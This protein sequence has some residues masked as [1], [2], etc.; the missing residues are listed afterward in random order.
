MFTVDVASLK[1]AT[2]ITKRVAPTRTTVPMA[3]NIFLKVV[4]GQ[5]WLHATDFEKSVRARVDGKFDEDIAV[6]VPPV[7]C[8]VVA[9]LQSPTAM[10]SLNGDKLR[11]E[12]GGTKMNFATM[13]EDMFPLM[14][15]PLPTTFKI[16]SSVLKDAIS[17]CLPFAS[18]DKSRPILNSVIMYSHNN[19]LT[20]SSL[21]GLRIS[22]YITDVKFDGWASIPVSSASE[23]AR[24]LSG[25]VVDVGCTNASISF[26]FCDTLIVTQLIDGQELD[27]DGYNLFSIDGAGVLNFNAPE[28]LRAV[29]TMSL[30]NGYGVNAVKVLP[31]KNS[32]T[33]TVEDSANG[34]DITIGADNTTHAKFLV[35]TNYLREAL[36]VVDGDARVYVY[37]DKRPVVLMDNNDNF[38]HVLFPMVFR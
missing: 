31:E 14:M 17:K 19:K 9:T 7:F 21:D 34:G 32:I 15:E 12:S 8:D 33:L 4:D 29:K 27:I 5:M 20:F 37:D 6:V 36:S 18:N 23:I 22:R 13:N 25:G 28:L 26:D 30:F 35:N 10:L 38:M 24:N 16:D 3:Q 1:K 11:L 2:E